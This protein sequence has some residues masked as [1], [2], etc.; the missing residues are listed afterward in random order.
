MS[1][2]PKRIPLWLK[3]LAIGLVLVAALLGVQRYLRPIAKVEPVISG[4]A[5]DAEPGSVVV[6]EHYAMQMKS[7]IAGRVL[8]KDYKLDTGLHVKEGDCWPTWTLRTS[9]SPSSRSRTRS[10]PR[11]SGSRSAPPRNLRS[12]AQR[13]TSSTRSA[14]SRWARSRT[15]STRRRAGWSRRSSSSWPSRRSATRRTLRPTR[16]TLRPSSSS[17]RR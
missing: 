13:A 10:N 17:L 1:D 3:L 9:R 2:K 12:R 7:A 4:D 15:A 8:N 11:S 5:V 14:C 16:M 6:K